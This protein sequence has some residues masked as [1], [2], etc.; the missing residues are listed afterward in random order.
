MLTRLGLLLLCAP[1]VALAPKDMCTL[2]DLVGRPRLVG[3]SQTHSESRQSAPRDLLGAGAAV[4]VGGA[5]AFAG[6]AAARALESRRSAPGT[7]SGSSCGAAPSPHRLGVR[8]AS[9]WSDSEGLSDSED[10][11]AWSECEEN[12]G[13]SDG[14]EEEEEKREKKSRRRPLLSSGRRSSSQRAWRARQ[15]MTC[16]TS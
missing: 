3:G 11:D 12:S 7:T 5:M 9:R 10:E 14:S 1:D 13:R 2:S 8:V 15:T 16:S 6:S 4:L